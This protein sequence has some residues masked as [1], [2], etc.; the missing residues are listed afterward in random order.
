MKSN[1]SI[2]NYVNIIVSLYQLTK[3]NSIYMYVSL[4]VKVCACV[5]PQR[6]RKI[7]REIDTI[8]SFC[9]K[10]VYIYTYIYINA[11]K[12]LKGIYIGYYIHQDGRVCTE[13][14]KKTKRFD[15]ILPS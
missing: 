3:K 12:T 13:T 15:G 5:S 4:Y 14:E 11:Q 1:Y 10:T 8:E 9:L 2:D 6:E 7:C